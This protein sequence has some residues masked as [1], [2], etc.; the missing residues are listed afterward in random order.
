[1]GLTLR[2]VLQAE[3]G[4]GSRRVPCVALKTRALVS[5]VLNTDD[6]EVC[7]SY[8]SPV[9]DVVGVAAEEFVTVSVAGCDLG[10]S[11]WGGTC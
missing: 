11:G 8:Q 3:V 6:R 2:I 4:I 7:W 5:A 1:M 9:D 10:D